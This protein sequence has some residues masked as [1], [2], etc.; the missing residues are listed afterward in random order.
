MG[1]G[2]W[3]HDFGCGNSCKEG[4]NVNTCLCRPDRSECAE[5]ECCNYTTYVLG[6]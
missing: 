3:T 5:T 6:G 4:H 1:G 2:A